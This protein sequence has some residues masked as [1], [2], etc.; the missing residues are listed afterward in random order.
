ML[1]LLLPFCPFP[2]KLVSCAAAAGAAA[3]VAIHLGS[4]VGL[5]PI[6]PA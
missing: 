5:L 2:G 4:I 1:L 6:L 3:A